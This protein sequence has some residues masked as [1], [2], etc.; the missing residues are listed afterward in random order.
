MEPLIPLGAKG[1][2]RGEELLCIGF[3]IRGCT[4]EGERYRW[5][6]YLLYGGPKAGYLWLMEEDGAFSLVRNVSAG[7][8]M[9]SGTK[10]SLRGTPYEF[11]QSVYATVEHV[12]GEFY[13]KVE[14]GEGAQAT[15]YEGPGGKLSVEET[16]SEVTHSFCE[17][18]P[19][20]EVRQ[21]FG[22]AKP[23]GADASGCVATGCTVLFV[24]FVLFL[25]LGAALSEC[26]G[27]SGDS[28]SSDPDKSM[29][30]SDTSGSSGAGWTPRPSYGGGK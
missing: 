4:V 10:A 5:R 12:V 20:S 3:V 1:S 8:V 18:V 27:A 24:L 29:G 30:S 19:E 2:L 21:A 28:D 15:E 23:P 13:W 17:P 26:D 16:G 22:L 7:D 11:K 25:V 14:V 6:E 9:V